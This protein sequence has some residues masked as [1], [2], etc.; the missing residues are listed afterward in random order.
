MADFKRTGE[1]VDKKNAKRL[2]ELS[3]KYKLRYFPTIVLI[4]PKNDKVEIIEGLK[5]KTPR[6]L[7][8]I[9]ETFGK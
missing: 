6:E 9:I 1:P 8:E 4:N 5:T 3:E 7:I 2:L